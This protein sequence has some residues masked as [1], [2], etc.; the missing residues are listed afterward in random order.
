[1]DRLISATARAERD[2]FWFRGFRRFVAPLLAQAAGGRCDLRILD[3]GCG[4][5]NNLTL[6]EPFGRASGFDLTMSALLFARE[7]GKTRVACASA[8]RFPFSDGC[9]DLVTAFDV[10]QCL[11]EADERAA[12]AEL[13]RVLR[14]GG[15][16]LL[17]VAAMDAL[18]G[19]HSILSH[20]V[21]RYGRTRLRAVL[22][23]A[24][25]DLVR[26]SHTNATL[27]PIVFVVRLIQRLLGLPISDAVPSAA[28]EIRMLPAPINAALSAVLALEAILV[29]RIDLPFGSSII[30]LARK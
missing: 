23:E 20:E 6:L 28:I 30:C 9:F 10:F 22:T 7:S 17:N 2:H 11:S 15:H 13:H 4:T 18:W 5:G 3:C 29:R 1:M 19:N 12:A 16:A 21:R 27:F 8:A 25:F 24:G 26:L 14:P